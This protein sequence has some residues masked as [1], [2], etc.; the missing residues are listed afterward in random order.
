MLAESMGTLFFCA[1]QNVWVHGQHLLRFAE[2][3]VVRTTFLCGR[4]HVC[5][6]TF[7]LPCN[8]VN[9]LAQAIKP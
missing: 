8:T 3:L 4:I 7:M 6:G 9:A 5:M 2:C 1:L